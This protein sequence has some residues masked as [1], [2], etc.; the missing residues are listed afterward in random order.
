MKSIAL[1][2]ANGMLASAIKKLVPDDFSLTGYDLPEF[3]LTS[4]SSVFELQEASPDIIINCAAFT[5]V[6][7]CE[8]Q[9]DLAMRVNGAGPGLLAE[10]AKKTGATLVH[11]STDFIF[12]G[13]KS[14]PYEEDD[15]PNPLSMYGRTKYQGEQSLLE[16]GIDNY[17]I[18]RTSW[19]YGAGG[20]NFVETIL[21]LASERERLNIIKDQRG[22]PTWTEDLARAIFALLE[23]DQFGIYHFSNEGDCSWYDFTLAIIDEAKGHK[24]PLKVKEITP[25]PTEAY[26]LPAT[27]PAYSVM[28]KMKIAS[29]LQAEVPFWQQS[30][31]NYFQLRQQGEKRGN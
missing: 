9:A 20:N 26:P 4:H 21:R 27:R 31:K 29:V 19:L 11:I 7:G 5:N 2:G 16:V 12:D 25:I 10:L 14:M 17:F 1:I 6:D 23:T 24:L 15:L 13:S 18:I 8:S 3:D 22:T 28:S 30:L